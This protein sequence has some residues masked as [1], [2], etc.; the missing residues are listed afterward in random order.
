MYIQSASLEQQAS[1]Y[2]GPIN[3]D[4]EAVLLC[5]LNSSLHCRARAEMLV[6]HLL[7]LEIRESIKQKPNKRLLE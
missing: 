3:R 7:R 4:C 6:Q 2:P 5:L 1:S